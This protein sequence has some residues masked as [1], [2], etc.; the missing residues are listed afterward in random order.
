MV[1]QTKGDGAELVFDVAPLSDQV[2]DIQFVDNVYMKDG[3]ILFV[4]ADIDSRLTIETFAPAGIPFP[5]PA[6]NG[7][8]DLVGTVWTPNTTHSGKYFVLPVEM[9]LFRFVNGLHILGAGSAE[10]TSPEPVLIPTPYITR[11]TLHNASTVKTLKACINM[12]LY[13]KSTI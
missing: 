10:V 11:F 13:R 6:S 8:M 7:N 9:K 3:T 12:G 4:D 5:A 1:T 2:K